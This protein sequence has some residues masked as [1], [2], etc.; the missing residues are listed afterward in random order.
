MIKV[1]KAEVDLTDELKVNFDFG[2][3]AL[4]FILMRLTLTCFG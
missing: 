2:S 4:I 1:F 3:V